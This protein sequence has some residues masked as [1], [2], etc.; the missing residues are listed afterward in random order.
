[1]YILFYPLK[2]PS[3]PVLILFKVLQHHNNL[4]WPRTGLEPT[5]I[6]WYHDY[7][8]T[9][10]YFRIQPLAARDTVS[11]HCQILHITHSPAMGW[12]SHF[13]YQVSREDRTRTCDPWFGLYIRFELMILPLLYRL[14]N[15]SAYWLTVTKTSVLANWT[16]SRN[17][18]FSIILRITTNPENSFRLLPRLTFTEGLHRSVHNHYGIAITS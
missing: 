7:L 17:V 10:A 2:F 5:F 12:L 14:T 15:F 8:Q 1:M 13:A 16:T 11:P 18:W 3:T 9:C 6:Y 4:L